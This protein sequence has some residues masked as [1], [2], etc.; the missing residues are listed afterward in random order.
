MGK[1]ILSDV[2][3]AIKND[4]RGVRGIADSAGVSGVTLY[5]WMRSGPK[6]PRLDTLTKVAKALGFSI[7]FEAESVKLV[8]FQHRDLPWADGQ[9]QPH[10]TAPP[11][12]LSSRQLRMLL[13]SL[14]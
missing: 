7:K 4:P 1:D 5:Y 3:R 10:R 12:A 8:P 14:Q 6:A 9:G 2:I 13:R 11:A